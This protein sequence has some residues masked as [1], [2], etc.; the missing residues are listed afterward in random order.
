MPSIH[1]K[2]IQPRRTQRFIEVK[3]LKLEI[4][5]KAPSMSFNALFKHKFSL[6][7]TVYGNN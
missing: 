5:M 7:G 6:F 1:A 3:E 4:K 2:R